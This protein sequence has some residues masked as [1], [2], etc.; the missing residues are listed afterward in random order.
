MRRAS[1]RRRE[2]LLRV[3]PLSPLIAFTVIS[4]AAAGI[5][6]QLPTRMEGDTLVLSLDEIE[7]IALE[8]SPGLAPAAAAV[9]LAEAQYGEARH[10]RF[11]PEFTLRNVWGPAPVAS[12]EF[13]EFGVLVSPDT[14]TG[15]GDLTWFTQLD[16]EFVQPVYTFGKIG[17]RI[18]A[19]KHQI[20]VRESEA[21][22]TRAAL[23]ERVRKVYWASLLAEEL[24][25]V[26]ASLTERMLEAETR[27][28]E[29]YEEGS[30]T[31]NDLFRFEIFRYE[32][33]S[34]TREIE[35]GRATSRAGLLS[36]LGLDPE[37][38]MRLEATSLEALDVTLDSLQVYIDQAV[39]L[40]PEMRALEAGVAA[41]RSLLNAARADLR[42]SF[43]LAGSFAFNH[44]P[45]RDDPR[46]PFVDNPTNFS[47]PALLFGVDWNL[48]FRR[49]SDQVRAEEF[50]LARVQAR[51]P[52]AQFQIAQEVRE[53]YL[54]V[55]RARQDV[56]EGQQ[57]LTAS[58]SLLRAEL[59]T[60]D[61][62][63]GNIEDVISA[64]ESNVEMTVE[65]FSNIER[66]NAMLTELSR[67]I[68]RD[69]PG[70]SD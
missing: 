10:A 65:Q 34:R 49:T 40:R 17:S 56:E 41:R 6:A 30:A 25:R 50:E 16:L 59:Q 26:S 18:D 52:A 14:M 13:T 46:N 27:L 8:N 66:L 7:A 15:L 43:F 60:F 45:G 48:N 63:L 4:V 22:M 62:G 2:S 53:A 11:L 20:E 37:T 64:F 42:P 3:S 31:Q 67:R 33:R 19:A 32:A 12:A 68:G 39:Q 5:E 24:E 54:E 21:A 57:A 58:E 55:R 61:I 47:R 44:S 35:V 69:L 51:V 70:V 38:P 29:L 23:L 36:L 28:N 1:R 9:G